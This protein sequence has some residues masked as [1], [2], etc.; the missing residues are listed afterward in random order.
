M[1]ALRALWLRLPRAL[2]EKL[3]PVRT[4]LE[5][6]QRWHRRYD[7][8]PFGLGES[9]TSEEEFDVLAMQ[10]RALVSDDF[11]AEVETATGYRLDLEWMHEL[12]AETQVIRRPPGDE[13]NYAYGVLLYGALRKRISKLPHDEAVRVLETGTAR[14]FSAVCMARGLQD[15]GRDGT[16]IT[17][18]LLHAERPILW[19]SRSDLG[20]PATRLDLLAPW[21]DLVNRYVVFLRGRSE[22]VLEQMG[23]SRFHFAFFDG[24][25]DYEHLSQELAF[26]ARHQ[27]TG[28][29]VICDDY[30]PEAFPGV[31]Q[32]VDEFLAGGNY[33]GRLFASRP[34]RGHMLLTRS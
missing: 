19:G 30:S 17:I 22:I 1:R 27:Q 5:L 33:E 16:I 10:A 3:R 2:R 31:S 4:P 21:S 24:A 18:D 7:S 26:I 20:G 9:E 29:M 14:G 6:W 23:V 34:G 28:D 13:N 15:D 8:N 11:V 25:H 12:G 32:A